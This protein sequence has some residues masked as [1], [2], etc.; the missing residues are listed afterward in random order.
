[1]RSSTGGACGYTDN[2]LHAGIFEIDKARAYND[3]PP[4]RRDVAVPARKA[5]RLIQEKVEAA[6]A[7]ANHL[8]SNLANLRERLALPKDSSL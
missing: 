6:K 3:R 2:I 7:D 4:H 5:L 8:E 1:M